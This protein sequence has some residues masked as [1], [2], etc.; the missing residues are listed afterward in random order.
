MP[1]KNSPTNEVG[2]KETTMNNE[3]IVIMRKNW[4][5]ILILSAEIEKKQK[6][7]EFHK[8]MV[9]KMVEKMEKKIVKV[10]EEVWY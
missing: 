6:I 2:K 9:E 7:V 5:M 3:Y 1:S 10:I 8:K 4:I